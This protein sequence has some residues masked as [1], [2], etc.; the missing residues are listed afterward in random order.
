MNAQKLMDAMNYL[1]DELLE[2]TDALRQKKKVHWKRWAALAACLCLAAGAWLLLPEVA[3]SK[4][5]SNGAGAEDGESFSQSLHDSCDTCIRIECSTLY[6][7][8]VEVKETYIIVRCDDEQITVSLEKYEEVPAL[9]PGQT[10]YIYY[11]EE[12]QTDEV[13]YPCVIDIKE[14]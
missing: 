9:S 4:D 12:E 14:D 6:A 13:I 2:Q 5:S 10:V 8:V 1:P 3:V 7:T 11:I